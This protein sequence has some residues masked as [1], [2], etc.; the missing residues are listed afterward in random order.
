MKVQ[1]YVK[2]ENRKP[3]LVFWI[4]VQVWIKVQVGKISKINKSAGWN[5][6]LQDG[7]F[8]ILLLWIMAFA[9]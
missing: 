6:A 7:I 1:E 3:T 5:K 9:L 4:I 2:K 8:G